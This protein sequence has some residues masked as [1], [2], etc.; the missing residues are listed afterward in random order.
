MTE[1]F[2]QINLQN[3]LLFVFHGCEMERPYVNATLAVSLTGVAKL[4]FYK[5]HCNDYIFFSKHAWKS[6]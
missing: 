6:L 3:T 5:C 4:L 1:L 2:V